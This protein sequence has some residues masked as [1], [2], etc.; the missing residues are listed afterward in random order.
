M[1][2]SYII[3]SHASWELELGEVDW[4]KILRHSQIRN[5]ILLKIEIR[6][7]RPV[8]H[9]LTMGSWETGRAD[10][11][12]FASAPIPGPLKVH[13]SELSEIQVIY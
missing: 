11:P 13:E 6:F 3:Y 5:D 8:K 4:R 7:A 2:N 9:E 10:T 1:V 12:T